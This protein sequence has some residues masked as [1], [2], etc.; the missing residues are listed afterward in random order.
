[1]A[2]AHQGPTAFDW[3]LEIIQAHSAEAQDGPDNVMLELA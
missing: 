2:R 3:L 1:L